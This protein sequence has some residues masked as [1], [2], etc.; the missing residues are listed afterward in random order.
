MIS[1]QDDFGTSALHEAAQAGWDDLADMLLNAGAPPS[2]K[3]KEGKAPVYYAAHNGN[4]KIISMISK[5]E[6]RHGFL[7]ELSASFDSSS[8]RN[9]IVPTGKDL[10]HREA[11]EEA[12]CDATEAGK[13]D[14]IVKLL[15]ENVS[16]ADSKKRGKS[17]MIA[18]QGGHENIFE[19]LL[20]AGANLSCPLSDR[21]PLHQAIRCSE[22]NMATMLLDRDANVEIRDELSRT[23]L[24]ET[25]DCH[26]LDGAHLLLDYGIDVSSCDHEGN[27]V[28]HEAAQRGAVEHALLFIDQGIELNKFNDEG[29]TPFH[30]AARHDRCR[31]VKDL[32]KKG[33]DINVIDQPHEPLSF[34]RVQRFMSLPGFKGS[35]TNLDA[36]TAITPP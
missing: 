23:A 14:V 28:L 13:L 1:R 19:K 12:F 9:G 30:L 35:C 2:P 21:I 20:D 22:D 16:L 6:I 36:L 17:A 32:L 26:D 25:L 34:E 5:E 29:L 31:I 24:F 4:T 33:A 10:G 27:T 18:I 7:P 3:N 15:K 11:L 8:G